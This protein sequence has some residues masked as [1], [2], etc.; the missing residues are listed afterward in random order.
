MPGLVDDFNGSFG[1]TAKGHEPEPSLDVAVT[2][3][4]GLPDGSLVSVRLGGCR[5]QRD[6]G[7]Q[8]SDQPMCF[9]GVS[10]SHALPLQV[11]VFAPVAASGTLPEG[12]TT[13]VQ[14]VKLKPAA[15]FG[16]TAGVSDQMSVTLNVT[17][18]MQMIPKEV[19]TSEV[20]TRYLQKHG[21]KER[22]SH[23]FAEL[24]QNLPEDP[25]HFLSERLLEGTGCKTGRQD[26]TT[27]ESSG[28]SPIEI[29]DEVE[30]LLELPLLAAPTIGRATYLLDFGS[31]ETGAYVYTMFQDN[32]IDVR[33]SKWNEPLIAGYVEPWR[34]EAFC[35]KLFDHFELTADK[36]KPGITI[37][38]GATGLHR[39]VLLSDHRMA[40]RTRQFFEEV[41]RTITDHLDGRE[42]TLQVFAPSGILEAELEVYAAEWLVS[43]ITLEAEEC[44]GKDDEE[45]M[46][47][48]SA[49]L[50]R[51]VFS[52]L[53][54]DA[55]RSLTRDE[56]QELV[57]LSSQL[58]SNAKIDRERLESML[59]H[60]MASMDLNNDSEISMDELETVVRHNS[61]LKRCAQAKAFCGSL[62]VGSGTSQLAIKGG[63]ESS[64]QLFS[65]P[66]G[67]QFPLVNGKL[68]KPVLPEEREMWRGEVRSTFRF[69]CLPSGLRGLYVGIAGVF[70]AA[71]LA[72]LTDRIVGKRSVVTRLSNVLNNLDA[73][74]TLHISNLTLVTELIDWVFHDDACFVFKREWECH[75]K[76]YVATWTLGLYTQQQCALATLQPGKRRTGLL[77]ATRLPSEKAIYP[78][79]PMEKVMQE[80]SDQLFKVP[81]VAWPL[82]QSYLLD[83]GSGE[84][85]FYILY[86][87]STNDSIKSLLEKKV[88]APFHEDFVAKGRVRDFCEMLVREFS[89]R[90]LPPKG[91]ANITAGAT[92][93]HREMLIQ[94]KEK[95]DSI[96]T[97]L[98][99]AEVELTSI[100]KKQ[101]TIQLFVPSGELEAQFELHAVEWLLG[102]ADVDMNCSSLPRWLVDCSFA[103]LAPVHAKDKEVRLRALAKLNT[104]GIKASDVYAAVPEMSGN[105]E[106]DMTVFQRILE[107]QPSL[108]ALLRRCNFSG[109]IS[110]GGGSSQ[111]TLSASSIH[112]SAQ[113]YSMPIGNRVPIVERLFSTPVTWSERSIWVQR[114]QTGLQRSSFPVGLPGV[115]VGISAMYYAAKHAGIEDR[116]VSKDEVVE[117]FA[118]ALA[119]LDGQDH[120]DIANLTLVKEII[121]RTFA[122]ESCF[123]FKRNWDVG[124]QRFVAGWVLGCF[125]RQFVADAPVCSES[126]TRIQRIAR[127]NH[128]RRRVNNMKNLSKVDEAQCGTIDE[129]NVVTQNED[130]CVE[131]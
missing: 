75:G 130:A 123:L 36:D 51:M 86:A 71:K 74:D 103:H 114:I 40:K 12:V 113:L 34:V 124:S 83:F 38:G 126:A 53:D 31:G 117:A 13:G 48:S 23:I 111:L 63:N 77:P 93:L 105:I 52:K 85:G 120:K 81:F 116:I 76:C 64:V 107:V 89:L 108:Q 73:E 66:I 72:N 62:S 8:R 44:N 56:L 58:S 3:H 109:T 33:S 95:H 9:R 14:Q 119:K 82:A 27:R 25:M 2:A 125:S 4:E 91:S 5:R 39:K 80:R 60:L 22:L 15:I 29:S 7:G 97:F 47:S 106:E 99:E 104:R 57:P 18:I 50:S 35:T 37:F 127:G 28:S 19:N 41:G 94:E 121:S 59:P 92:G 70:H 100:L 98:I 45:G 131:R 129:T 87:D 43:Q 6:L 55:S 90:N 1:A 42:V 101:A 110:A 61:L 84:I 128:G 30:S 102:R 79:S 11:D 122:E 21:I 16:D 20:V 49:S 118:V 65:L 69:G 68:S 10:A 88:K 115:F 54:M 17:E 26:S 46:D 67:N 78:G 96:L 24:F 32:V 112:S